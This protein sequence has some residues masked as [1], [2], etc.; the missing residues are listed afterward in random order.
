MLS[1]TYY[2]PTE[3]GVPQSSDD[4]DGVTYTLARKLKPCPPVCDPVF[5]GG[6]ILRQGFLGLYSLSLYSGVS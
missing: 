2:I 4:D 6:A 1:V 5:I 3:V